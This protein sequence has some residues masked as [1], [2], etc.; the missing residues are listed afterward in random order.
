M[1]IKANDRI[2]EVKKVFFQPKTVILMQVKGSHAYAVAEVISDTT[3]KGKYFLIPAH[4][5]QEFRT[6]SGKA[7]FVYT[8]DLI[9][10][11]EPSEDEK[12]VDELEF[13]KGNLDGSNNWI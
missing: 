8:K 6:I 3:L 7:Y 10:E 9:C 2:V 4:C 1:K 5:A 11:V 12:I 13:D